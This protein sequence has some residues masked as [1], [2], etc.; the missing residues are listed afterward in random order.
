MKITKIQL[1]ARRWALVLAAACACCLHAADYTQAI[2]SARSAIL[3]EMSRTSTPAVTVAVVDGQGVVWSEAFGVTASRYGQPATNETLFS[4]QSIS[5]HY[6]ALAF[7]RLAERGLISLDDPLVKYVP[8]FHVKSGWPVDYNT[9]T[10]RRLLSHWSG[11]Q[12]EAPVGNNGDPSSPS[13]DA[14]VNSIFDTWLRFPPGERFAYSNLGVDLAGLALERVAGKPFARVVRDE[15]FLP[16]G[17]RSSTFEDYEAVK[18]MSLASG[19]YDTSPTAHRAIPMIPSGGMYS[20]VGDMA[21]C[22][23][24]H[25]A[26]GTV[27]KRGRAGRPYPFLRQHSLAEMYRPQ[28][29]PAGQVPGYG[30][31][32]SRFLGRGALVYNHGGGGFGYASM[33]MWIP[34]YGMGVALLSNSGSFDTFNTAIAALDAFL[35]VKLGD[36]PAW[37]NAAENLAVVDVPLNELQKLT[38]TYKGRAGVITVALSGNSLQFTRGPYGYQTLVPHGALLFS[39]A[40][41]TPNIWTF[42]VDAAGNGTG[43][44]VLGDETYMLNDRPGDPRGPNLSEWSGIPGTYGL[45]AP[46]GVW[47]WVIERRNGYLYTYYNGAPVRL[48]QVQPGIF[49]EP[50]GF[51]WEIHGKEAIIEGIRCTR[52]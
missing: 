8:E 51:I 16:L 21:K 52:Q 26:R 37:S 12:H 14:H 35:R 31:G 32:T 1:P 18:A 13:F 25:L 4:L 45:L 30:L 48:T 38:G 34:D 22:I 6:T 9:I 39:E 20:T 3:Q 5:K 10:M 43:L 49:T 28:F 29:A 40:R 19:H 41:A 36:L 23:A 44:T 33:Q 17:M 7:L 15:V 47:G 46:F 27:G 2:S 24:M 42:H 11:L 50:D